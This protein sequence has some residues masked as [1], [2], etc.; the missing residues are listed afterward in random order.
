M[1]SSFHHGHP[2]LKVLKLKSELGLSCNLI[3][4]PATPTETHQNQN[5]E[6]SCYFL[7]R[8]ATATTT[9][10]TQKLHSHTT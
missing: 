10:Q 6:I 5:L 2:N 8:Q 9:H 3:D 1:L 4:H 7:D